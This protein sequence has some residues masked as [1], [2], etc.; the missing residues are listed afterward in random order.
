MASREA[1]K[2]NLAERQEERKVGAK[3]LTCF[4]HIRISTDFSFLYSNI[5]AEGKNSYGPINHLGQSPYLQNQDAE[6]R[7]GNGFP[8]FMYIMATMK[9][10]TMLP[11]GTVPEYVRL[12]T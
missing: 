3:Q 5:L 1:E 9:L 11:C 10:E 6:N 12:H 2:Y 8:R 7:W 4:C